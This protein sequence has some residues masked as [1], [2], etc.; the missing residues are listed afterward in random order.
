M[1]INGI[2][3]DFDEN[4]NDVN[5]INDVVNVQNVNTNVVNNDSHSPHEM[6]GSNTNTNI[7]VAAGNNDEMQLNEFEQLNDLNTLS[8][9]NTLNTMNAL[10]TLNI[11]T[12]TTNEIG[13]NGISNEV[14][15]AWKSN[16]IPT[17]SSMSLMS[18]LTTPHC[19]TN[20]SLRYDN[21]FVILLFYFVVLCFVFVL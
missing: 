2:E 13:I 21:V 1:S 12:G 15:L 6:N 7:N 8:N 4:I 18:L 3:L 5:D 11:G 20:D 17:L 16:G 9:I 14:N 10:N 19:D